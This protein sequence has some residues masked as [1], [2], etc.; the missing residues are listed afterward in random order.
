MDKLL[1][2][3]SIPNTYVIKY[4]Y[5]LFDIDKRMNCPEVAIVHILYAK[6]FT[7][8]ASSTCLSLDS[9]LHKSVFAMTNIYIYIYIMLKEKVPNQQLLRVIMIK[10]LSEPMNTLDLVIASGQNP[11]MV[12]SGSL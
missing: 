10:R 6:W 9:V 12:P 2:I 11:W 1:L 8:N 7:T 4:S 5:S 3:K